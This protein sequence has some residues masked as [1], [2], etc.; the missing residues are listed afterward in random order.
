MAET[1]NLFTPE[2]L[3]KLDALSLSTRQS[4]PGTGAGPRRA[5][6]LGASVEFSDF[7][8]YTPG[9]DYRRIDW[10]AYAR[11]E[12]LF[13]R[14]YRAEENLNVMLLLDTSRS[15]DWGQPTKLHLARQIAGALAYI[16]LSHDDRVGVAA[17]GNDIGAYLPPLGNRANVWQVWEFLES[18]QCRGGTDLGKALVS[19]R[20]L[21]PSPGLAV[22]LTDLLTESDWRRGLLALLGLRQEVVLAQVLAPEEL[23]PGIS[24]DWQLVDDED[25]RPLD[26]TLTPR[27]VKMYRERLGSYVREVAE[28]C[29]RHTITFMQFP[30]TISIEDAVLRLLRRAGEGVQ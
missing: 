10:N 25:E 28:F 22:V 8:S 12:R 30:S 2:F 21:R 20:R 4:F 1:T 14:L 26:V 9:D 17:L 29:H 6:R 24:G 11:L 13:L 7:R 19:L 3:R 18:L 5:P 27:A 15:M 23:E 16:G